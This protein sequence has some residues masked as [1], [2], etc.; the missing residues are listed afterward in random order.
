VRFYLLLVRSNVL[1]VLLAAQSRG[2]LAGSD[3]MHMVSKTK[4]PKTP[5]SSQKSFGCLLIYR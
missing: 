1:V 4:T 2:L 3:H 5:M